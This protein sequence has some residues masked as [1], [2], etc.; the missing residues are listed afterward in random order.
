MKAVVFGR[1]RKEGERGFTLPELMIA[2]VLSSFIIVAGGEILRQTITVSARNTDAT[3]AVMQVQKAGFWVN[4]DGL[5][6]QSVDTATEFLTL[7]WTEWD[8]SVRVI[9][10]SVVDTVD[11]HGYTLWDLMRHDNLSD[12][13]VLV[14]ESL[15]PAGTSCT[16][17][18]VSGELTLNVAAVVDDHVESRTFTIQPRAFDQ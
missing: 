12:E 4:Q 5:Q 15:D 14:S 8:K 11:E 9:T 7:S 18:G 17:D 2:I 13:T 16:W 1:R 3:V 6:A 10:Y